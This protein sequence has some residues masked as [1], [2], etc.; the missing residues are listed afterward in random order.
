LTVEAK[1]KEDGT[2]GTAEV[3]GKAQR[4]PERG[5]EKEKRT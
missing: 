3:S 5:Q 1:A 4:A 2:A